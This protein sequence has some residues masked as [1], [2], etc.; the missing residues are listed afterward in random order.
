MTEKSGEQ[1]NNRSEE[2]IEDFIKITAIGQEEEA[3][4]IQKGKDDFLK[5][6]TETGM[7]LENKDH[8]K[9]LGRHVTGVINELFRKNYSLSVMIS[10]K[11]FPSVLIDKEGVPPC[12]F[13]HSRDKNDKKGISAIR[14]RGVN[15]ILN[16]N[17]FSEEMAHF[18]RWYFEP[19][20]KREFITEEFFGFLGKRLW[21]KMVAEGKIGDADFLIDQEEQKVSPKR[22]VLDASNNFKRLIELSELLKHDK[23]NRHDDKGVLSD[24]EE[25]QGL[26]NPIEVLKFARRDVLIHQRGYEYASKI[27]LDGI[28]DWKK[29]FS[30]SNQEVRKRFFTPNPDYSGL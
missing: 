25:Q 1:L 19:E 2:M 18:Y 13:I 15:D 7:D 16:G 21:Q 8:V 24:K 12:C 27:N 29:F 26:D 10:D 22:S 3:P 28:H 11:S 6:V 30:L 23:K 5:E 14:L 20:Q 17:Y 9:I 4:A